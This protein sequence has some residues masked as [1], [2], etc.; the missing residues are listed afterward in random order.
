MLLR[1][2]AAIGAVA[3]LTTPALAAELKDADYTAKY[4]GT[5]VVFTLAKPLEFPEGGYWTDKLPAELMDPTY[6]LEKVN[7]QRSAAG[8]SDLLAEDASPF[9][10]TDVTDQSAEGIYTFGYADMTPKEVELLLSGF[11][12]LRE[13]FPAA[14]VSYR[15]LLERYFDVASDGLNNP[16]EFDKAGVKLT[17]GP[18]TNVRQI[19]DSLTTAFRRK[20]GGLVRVNYLTYSES[21]LDDME[22]RSVS[23]MAVLGEPAS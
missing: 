9:Q 1:L 15:P 7:A 18:G 6:I 2:I 17:I 19:S 10:F 16:L 14:K 22:L 23:F 12:N 20:Y 21:L 13:V 3:I 5:V 8:R 4:F 11:N